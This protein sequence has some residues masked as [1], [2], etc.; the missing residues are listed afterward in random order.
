MTYYKS[1]NTTELQ[2]LT[3]IVFKLYINKIIF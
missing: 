1:T 3:F 2:T